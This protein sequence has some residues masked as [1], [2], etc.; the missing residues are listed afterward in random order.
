MDWAFKNFGYEDPTNAMFYRRRAT[1]AL[2][3]HYLSTGRK[4]CTLGFS[5]GKQPIDRVTIELFADYVPRTVDNF[6]ELIKHPP[7]IGSIVH[8]VVRGGW[9]QMGDWQSGSG[10]KSSTVSGVPLKD[11]AFDLKHDRPGLLSM[12]HSG[13]DTCGSQF[14]ISTKPLPFFNDKYKVFGRVVAGMRVIHQMSRV[15][16]ENER[17]VP[18]QEIRILEVLPDICSKDQPLVAE[19]LAETAKGASDEDKAAL[20]VQSLYRG[21]SARQTTQKMK[22]DKEEKDAAIK[23]QS[24]YRGKA[25]RMHVQKLQHEKEEQ[26]AAVKVQA[27]QRGKIARKRVDGMKA[28]NV[29]IK[30]TDNL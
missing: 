11:E 14:F 22:H 19:I 25:S 18:Q 1:K 13:S 12:A 27:M 3:A 2:M 17:P 29:Q 6:I 23:V 5:I 15:E 10:G 28:G 20:K 7:F 24:L 30:S 16:T 4:Y 26:K 9:F 8:R 21:K